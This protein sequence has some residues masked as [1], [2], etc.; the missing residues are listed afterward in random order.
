VC[1]TIIAGLSGL[2]LLSTALLAV[3]WRA[4]RTER[5]LRILAQH[6]ARRRYAVAL[7]AAYHH[8][9]INNDAPARHL[10]ALNQRPDR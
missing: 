2:V 5:T 4:W 1:D 7:L 10:H 8:G 3:L 6:A 9:P